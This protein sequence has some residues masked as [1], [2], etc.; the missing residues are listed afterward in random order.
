MPCDCNWCKGEILSYL[1]FLSLRYK[2]II[3]DWILIKKIN[4]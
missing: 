2:L 4:E 1:S 3:D